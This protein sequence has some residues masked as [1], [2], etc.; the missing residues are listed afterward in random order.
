MASYLTSSVQLF[1][2]A[3]GSFLFPPE[4]SSVAAEIDWLFNF[5]YYLCL[6]F[7]VAIVAVMIYFVMIYRQREGHAALKS[8]S[9]GNVLEITWSVIPS[10]LVLFIFY[11]G[12]TGYM[13]IREVP[14]D[15]YEIQVQAKQFQFNF[16]YPNGYNDTELHLPVDRDV[17]FVLSSQDV[18]HSFYIPA[19]RVKLD[20]VPGRYNKVW[21]TPTVTTG[22]GI[23]AE[24]HQPFNLFCAEY[25]GTQ[26]SR[27]G[28]N[29]YVHKPGE[30]ELWLE[31]AGNLLKK[32]PPEKAGEILYTKNC[33]QCH[34]LDGQMII[35]PSFQG[36]WGTKRDVKMRDGSMQE[37]VMD[38]NYVLESIRNPNAKIALN[39]K[40]YQAGMP[41]FSQQQISDEEVNA[42]ISFLKTQK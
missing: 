40:G 21:A 30:L 31:D 37:V 1:A 35:G 15:A 34:S 20:C 27:M 16:V 23:E 24:N 8:P 32:Y 5:I 33:K 11:F 9:H 22:D 3:G 13:N 38:E 12:F 10:I 4:G 41:A 25:C 6:F 17:R 19:F 28:A 14:E 18:L 42:I 29:V 36:S 26:N 7:F 39:K 2:E